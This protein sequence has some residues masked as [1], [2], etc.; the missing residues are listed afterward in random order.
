MGK[1]HPHY[2][3]RMIINFPDFL[4]TI[5]FVAFSR[6][7]G[8]YGK[9]IHFPYAEIYHRMGIGWKK[10]HQY[11]GKNMIID[12]SDFPHTIGFAAFSRTVENLS[13]NP[14]I[15]CMM[16]SVNFFV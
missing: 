8:S 7:V 2:G 9:P 14:S 11:Y 16:T 5:G 3:K 1:K 4:H 10:K 15:S 6:T 12:F 13:E